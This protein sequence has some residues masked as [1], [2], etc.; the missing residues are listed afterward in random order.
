[1]KVKIIKVHLDTTEFKVPA[2]YVPFHIE[3]NS[4]E[5]VVFLKPETTR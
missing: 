4:A 2:G 5:W 1:M 3:R